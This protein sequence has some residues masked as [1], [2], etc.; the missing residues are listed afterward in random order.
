MRLYYAPG[1]CA[2]SPHIV[3]REA[4]LNVDIS[5]VTFSPEGRTTEQGED[6]FKV[7]TKG[8]YVPAL[9]LDDDEVLM[10][11]A[12]IIQY[13]ADQAPEKKLAPEKGTMQHYRLLEW[14]TFIS[15]ELHKGFG[16]LFRADAPESEKELAGNKLRKRLAYVESAL[17][18]KDYLL[19]DFSIADA[20]LYTIL[21]WSP[22]GN[23]DFSA[24]PNISKYM[25]RM[26]AREG[27]ATA[28]SKEGLAAYG[29]S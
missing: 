11:G 25:P 22:R 14:I 9:R 29:A 21:R 12:A 6:F 28:L 7:N 26:E 27:V 16:P 5:R 20:Y 10:E 8:G 17:E 15:T 23:I 4:G 2:L 1:S 24:Y 13:L 18:G 3:A 19:G